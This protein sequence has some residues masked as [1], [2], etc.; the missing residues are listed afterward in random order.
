[1]FT[2][3]FVTLYLKSNSYQKVT[4]PCA[5][6]SSS[7]NNF[8]QLGNSLS[9][10]TTVY[11][12]LSVMSGENIQISPDIDYAFIGMN[13]IKAEIDENGELTNTSTLLKN[14]A[15]VI[16]FSSKKDY[17]SKAMQ[18]YEIEMA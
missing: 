1:M 15:K 9:T 7:T 4:Y 8:S 16:T 13:D 14:G 12:P 18:H 3:N 2:N 10:K 17:G 11:I 6:F 5:V